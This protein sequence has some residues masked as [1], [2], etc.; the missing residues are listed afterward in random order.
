[1]VG[2]MT[3]RPTKPRFT[4][5]WQDRAGRLS[6]L[7]LAAFV[8]ILAPGLWLFWRAVTGDLGARPYDEAIH[9]SG[10]WAI[11]LLFVSLLVTPL[12][13]QLAW[14]RLVTVRRMVGVAAFGYAFLHLGLYVADQGVDLVKVA[15]E[16]V[17]RF[18]LAIGFVA[19]AGL[20]ALAATS[21]DGAIR[22]LGKRWRRLHWLVY[23]I[24]VIAVVHYFLQTKLDVSEPVLMAG[25][26]VWMLGYRLVAR[27]GKPGIAVLVGLTVGTALLTA[28]IEAAWYALGTGADPL[29]VLRANLN[30]AFGLRPALWVG[31]AALA[32]VA[33]VIGRRA[34]ERWPLTPGF[35]AAR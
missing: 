16:I 6:P 19:V 2:I 28:G 7:K 31:I 23:P 32:V 14:P 1:M 27:A 20:A 15:S 34:L 26:L 3:A 13:V 12:R 35:G 10:L 5:P 22:R 24:A 18:Y 17:L 11:R 4:L 29:R 21:T 9:Q 30:V 25:F 33:V 8:G